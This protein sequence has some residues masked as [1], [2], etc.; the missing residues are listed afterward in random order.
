MK[1]NFLSG[2]R[3]KKR[4]RKVPKILIGKNRKEKDR[5]REG[6]GKEERERKERRK[7][8]KT[9]YIFYILHTLYT[10]IKFLIIISFTVTEVMGVILYLY[11]LRDTT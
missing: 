7:K 6:G 2:Y 11:L 3:S 4:N 10:Y 9:L 1:V 8:E 5:R